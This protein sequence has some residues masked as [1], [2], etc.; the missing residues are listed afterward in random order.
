MKE[1]D[2]WHL[3]PDSGFWG[4]SFQKYALQD[5]SGLV[6]RIATATRIRESSLVYLKFLDWVLLCTNQWD[7]HSIKTSLGLAPAVNCPAKNSHGFMPDVNEEL[8]IA[9]PCL[10]LHTVARSCSHAGS[11]VSTCAVA[12]WLWQVPPHC[13]TG[14]AQALISLLTAHL[15]RKNSSLSLLIQTFI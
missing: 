8:K 14:F 5:E 7:N 1:L 2:E 4:N 9:L 6:D 12:P 10:V 15:G 3:F 11:C 13:L